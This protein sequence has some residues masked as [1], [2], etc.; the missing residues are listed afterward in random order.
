M[1]RFCV[2]VLEL[3]ETLTVAAVMFPRCTQ[4]FPAAH[5]SGFWRRSNQ[6][7]VLTSKVILGKLLHSLKL[8]CFP[9][10]SFDLTGLFQVLNVE[11]M[12]GS[13]MSIRSR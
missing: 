3:Y 2:C 7:L 9:H 1:N 4:W 13:Q 12:E 5:S 8:N 11:V 10:S 6:G